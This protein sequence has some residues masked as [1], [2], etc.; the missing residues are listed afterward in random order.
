MHSSKKKEIR[1]VT[2]KNTQH[3]SKNKT[4]SSSGCPSYSSTHKTKSTKKKRK[5]VN[6]TLY[7]SKRKLQLYTPFQRSELMTKKTSKHPSKNKNLP[8]VRVIPIPTSQ[9]IRAQVV[10]TSRNL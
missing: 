2:K 1:L 6:D 3:Q 10:T 7:P 9:N 4:Y 8:V 5:S